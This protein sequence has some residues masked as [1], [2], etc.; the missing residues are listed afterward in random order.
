MP[1]IYHLSIIIYHLSIIFC[2]VFQ[3][4]THISLLIEGHTTVYQI[5]YFADQ[6]KLF[7]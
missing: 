6:N 3:T 7:S 1:F 2:A 5:S 4:F